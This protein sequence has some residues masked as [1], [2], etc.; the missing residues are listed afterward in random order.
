MRQSRHFPPRI[1]AWS[2]AGS[3][4]IPLVALVAFWGHVDATI[5]GHLW[6]TTLPVLVKNSVVLVVGTGSFA[7]AV[8]T[9][10]GW[11]TG[12]YTFPG[13]RLFRWALIMPLALPTYVFAFIYLGIFD[14]TGPVQTTLMRWFPESSLVPVD[15]RQAPFICFV[16]GLALFPYVYLMAHNAF[17][18]QGRGVLEAAASLGHGAGSAFWR[19]AL[20]LARP[21]LA[22]GTMLVVMETVADFGAVSIFNYA[23]F[24][25][26]IYKTWFGFFSVKS[27]AQLSSLLVAVVLCCALVE[28]FLRRRS[29]YAAVGSARCLSPHRLQGWKALLATGYALS[30]L[31]LGFFLPV[32]Q[33]L[34]WTLRHWSTQWSA[35]YWGYLG[36]TATLGAGAAVL[37]TGIAL[38]LVCIQR[39]LPAKDI[40]T[41][42]WI[43][44]LGYAIPGT[45]LA[46]GV[47]I[48]AGWADSITAAMSTLNRWN[49][50]LPTLQGG[51]AVLVFGY[52]VRFMVT[53]V[54]TLESGMQRIPASLD[55]AAALHGSKGAHLAGRIHLPLLRS[56]M[57]TGLILATIEVM[58]EMPLTLM[59]RPFGW[60][61]LAVKIYELTSEGLWEKAAVPAVVLVAAGCLAVTILCRTLPKNDVE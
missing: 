53:G 24:T 58:K 55:Q 32:G 2:A 6:A 48:A 26:A 29:R 15:L 37:I 54:N 17:S 18:S 21:W 39:Q 25:T 33:L 50:S 20:P 34:Y 45:V 19:V 57:G 47:S 41:A 8:G 30:I 5:W 49:V 23:T 43:S 14:F 31:V 11:L 44:R 1:V 51:V 61:T 52:L 60:D 22:A 12:V 35:E 16:L 10:L 28:Q 27:A 13:S 9:S 42:V 59:L 36:N 56:S 38:V 46:V 3:I 40:T 7:L 4:G